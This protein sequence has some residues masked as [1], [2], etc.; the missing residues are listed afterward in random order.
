MAEDAHEIERLLHTYAERIDAGDFAGVGELFA[1]GRIAAVPGATREQMVSGRDAV[2]A[3]YEATT[4]RYDDD[5]TPH[6][7]HLVTNVVVDLEP[8]GATASARSYYTVLQQ[9]GGS[10]L[11]PIVAGRYHDTFQRV[12]GCWYFDTRTIF[13]DLLGD[14]SR[15]LLIDL[16]RAGIPRPTDG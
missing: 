9:V 11:Q 12:D 1:H 14:V 5:G 13:V 6:T 10:P 16:G 7:K 8:G 4:R 15:H 2:V 3:L